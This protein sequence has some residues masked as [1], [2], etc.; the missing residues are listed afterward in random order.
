MNL[1]MLAHVPFLRLL[2]VVCS[3][4]LVMALVG[5]WWPK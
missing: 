3:V 2:T 5:R 1:D 4:G